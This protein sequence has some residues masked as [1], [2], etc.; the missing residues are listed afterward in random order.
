MLQD[1]EKH[2]VRQR[3]ENAGAMADAIADAIAT[4]AFSFK[5]ES[6]RL[7][8]ATCF[9]AANDTMAFKL[10][11]DSIA[12]SILIGT[13]ETLVERVVQPQRMAARPSPNITLLASDN[14]QSHVGKCRDQKKR[15]K[16]GVRMAD[17]QMHAT[18]WGEWGISAL[19][20]RT[21]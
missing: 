1:E 11:R 20:M 8:H 17:G 12:N 15:D 3:K 13:T 16:S 4:L 7:M 10:N 14:M 19:A 6:Q 2:A 5:I 9:M 21:T 18:V